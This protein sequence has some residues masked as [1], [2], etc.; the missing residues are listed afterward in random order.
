MLYRQRVGTRVRVPKGF[1]SSF[2][3]GLARV[4]GGNSA[5]ALMPRLHVANHGAAQQLLGASA[6]EPSFLGSL[7]PDFDHARSY[8][9]D[10]I[11]V[12]G[13]TGRV[14]GDF[15]FELAGFF[16][17]FGQGLRDDEFVEM[18]YGGAKPVRYDTFIRKKIVLSR[19]TTYENALDEQFVL[20]GGEVGAG[21]IHV[22]D[23]NG[24]KYDFQPPTEFEFKK[25]YDRAREAV[26]LVGTG[27]YDSNERLRRLVSVNVIYSD[28]GPSQPFDARLDE[29]GA[30]P[31]GWYN[32]GNPAPSAEAVN[33]MRI[34][35][36]AVALQPLPS[37]YLYPLPDGGVA[38]EWSVGLWEASAEVSVDGLS[39][40]LNA[41]NSVTMEELNNL[42]DLKH[43]EFMTDF[44]AFINTVSAD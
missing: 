40:S 42:L 31:S 24:A 5:V 22:R 6:N 38:A 4:D 39:L 30:T 27:L 34:F 1:E 20:H 29:I 19:E 37:P 25:A 28:G 14:P 12:V 9:D 8:I 11:G 35:L 23:V 10:L 15:P 32:D 44:V 26:R 16:N 41:V 7:Y 18:G 43:T 13:Q 2:Q 17:S 36:S 21:V 33:S 3:I